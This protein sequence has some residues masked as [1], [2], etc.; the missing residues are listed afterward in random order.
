MNSADSIDG[1]LFF[2]DVLRLYRYV[3]NIYAF[4]VSRA[5]LSREGDILYGLHC[6]CFCKE[7]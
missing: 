2:L 6:D 7:N 1:D 5:P 3:L 4:F